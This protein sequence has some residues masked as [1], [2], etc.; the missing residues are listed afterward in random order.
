MNRSS[1]SPA[2][3]RPVPENRKGIV[4]RQQWGDRELV[5]RWT[6]EERWQTVRRLS[7]VELL[8]AH[9]LLQRERQRCAL[10]AQRFDAGDFASRATQIRRALEILVDAVARP[11][12]PTMPPGVRA[13]RFPYE[14]PYPPLP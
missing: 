12:S 1:P 6:P 9:D 13:D 7:D 4:L 5:F 3:R 11:A 8:E 2:E 14:Q 10:L